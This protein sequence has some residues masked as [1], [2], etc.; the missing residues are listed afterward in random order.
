MAS[1]PA[2]T[3]RTTIRLRD[4]DRWP[5]IGTRTGVVL[6]VDAGVVVRWR[7]IK[8]ETTLRMEDLEMVEKLFPDDRS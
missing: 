3:P 8:G 1:E 6:R 5:D 4:P 2:L 7:G